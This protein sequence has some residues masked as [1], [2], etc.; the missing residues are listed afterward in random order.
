DLAAVH[1]AP[2]AVVRGRKGRDRV[3]RRAHVELGGER[4]HL[5]RSNRRATDGAQPARTGASALSLQ[6]A[7]GRVSA[8]ASG[9]QAHAMRVSGVKGCAQ[10]AAESLQFGKGDRIANPRLRSFRRQ[11][12]SLWI[13]PECRKADDH[14][15]RPGGNIVWQ[16]GRKTHANKTI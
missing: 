7:T 9:T 2:R 4:R 13:A 16:R 11:S 12:L 1:V 6:K 15:L 8:Q 14:M 10:V 5:P 3:H